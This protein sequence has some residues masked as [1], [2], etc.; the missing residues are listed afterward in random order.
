MD[1]F[2][3]AMILKLLSTI[4]HKKERD[5][6]LMFICCCAF[7]RYL[8]VTITPSASRDVDRERAREE[9]LRSP[10]PKAGTGKVIRRWTKLVG[11]IK[12]IRLMRIQ[13]LRTIWQRK[14]IAKDPLSSDHDK[15][16]EQSP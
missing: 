8:A 15:Y 5:N 12:Y 13:R 11:G 14:R 1:S 3:L 7:V 4:R 9:V 6:N 10:S 16:C 2:P